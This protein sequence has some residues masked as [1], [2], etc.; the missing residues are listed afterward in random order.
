MALRI[1]FPGDR[2]SLSTLAPG[3]FTRQNFGAAGCTSDRITADSPDGVLAGMVAMYS[4][5]YEVD[6]CTTHAPVGIFLNDAAGSPFENTPAV[7]SGKITVMRSMGSYETDIYETRNEADTLDVTYTAGDLLYASDFGLLT[8]EDLSATC[9]VVG[10]VS[11][12]PS[13]TDP[14]LGFDLYI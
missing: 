10:R 3:A 5:N 6:I 9:P 13:P 12:A 2:N 7:A 14:W 8:T 4:D 11:K 1:L